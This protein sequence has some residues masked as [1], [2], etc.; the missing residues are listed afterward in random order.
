MQRSSHFALVEILA[1]SVCMTKFAWSFA[2]DQHTV[3]SV[4]LNLFSW[5]DLSK[6][7]KVILASEY[8]D[9][10]VTPTFF[11]AT[12]FLRKQLTICVLQCR[13]RLCISKKIE[14]SAKLQE[15][16]MA[17]KQGSNLTGIPVQR[18]IS[19]SSETSLFS[20]RGKT[21]EAAEKGWAAFVRRTG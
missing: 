4:S 15:I 17:E 11:H 21:Q 3:H 7:N 13:T 14:D 16:A 9:G 12:Y 8:D 20:W 5:N 2:K 19:R 18:S 6:Q 10:K 1:W